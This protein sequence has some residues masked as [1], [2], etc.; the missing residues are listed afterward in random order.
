[1]L[2]REFWPNKTLG[3]GEWPTDPLW[4]YL[5]SLDE[6]N[7]DAPVLSLNRQQKV[8]DPP[9]ITRERRYEKLRKL[10]ATPFSG[11]LYPAEAKAW[12]ETAERIFN[13]MQCILEEKFDYV[14][15]LLQGDAYN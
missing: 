14:V 6:R 8:H 3:E 4:R 2:H 12:L 15:F 1:M 5:I 9:P 13:L 11:S 7:R 10:G